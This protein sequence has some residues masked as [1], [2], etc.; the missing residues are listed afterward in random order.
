MMLVCIAMIDY[1]FV[2]SWSHNMEYSW[3]L[4][5]ILH[6]KCYVIGCYVIHMFIFSLCMDFSEC[7]VIASSKCIVV[8]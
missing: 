3:F 8:F 4:G 1:T 2:L 6:W 5:Y 7:K